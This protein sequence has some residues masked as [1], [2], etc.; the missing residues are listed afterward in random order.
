[1]IDWVICQNGGDI[2][3]IHDRC[4]DCLEG[5]FEK[6][7]PENEPKLLDI[8]KNIPLLEESM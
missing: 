6:I 2:L 7:K 1:V 3:R 4:L 8:R 5:N